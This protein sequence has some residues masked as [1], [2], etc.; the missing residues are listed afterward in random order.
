MDWAWP[1]WTRGCRYA[2][3][4]H[5]VDSGCLLVTL[6]HYTI[7]IPTP[8]L[9]PISLLTFWRFPYIVADPTE[10]PSCSYCQR[11][12]FNLLLSFF[13]REYA[14]AGSNIAIDS[15]L[16]LIFK[17]SCSTAFFVTVLVGNGVGHLII[18]LIAVWTPRAFSSWRLEVP[19]D[20][21]RDIC[22]IRR[23]GRRRR[24]VCTDRNNGWPW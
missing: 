24:C 7:I 2:F 10:Q 15:M 13:V 20:W 18:Q 4:L 22:E 6:D 16:T 17:C 21:R 11:K 19:C 3:Q 9:R 14:Y 5:I 8:F 12:R 23:H 1:C